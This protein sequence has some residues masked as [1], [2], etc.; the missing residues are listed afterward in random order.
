M[1]VDGLTLSRDYVD[2]ELGQ[3]TLYGLTACGRTVGALFLGEGTL[4]VRSPGPQRTPQ[5]HDRFPDLPG[6]AVLDAAY[7]VGSDG[8]VEDLLAQAGGLQEGRVPPDVWGLVQGRGNGFRYVNPDGWRPPGEILAA[9][10]PAQG[11]LMIEART[12]GV[13]AARVERSLEVLSPWITWVWA[14]T[15]PLGDPREPGLWLRRPTGSTRY[16]TY[17]GFP[18]EQAVADQGTPFALEEPALPWDL[19]A[20]TLSVAVSGPIGPDRQLETLHGTARLQLRARGD[21]SRHVVLAM[22]EGVVSS[23]DHPWDGWEVRGVADADGAPL[24][25]LRSGNRI[26]VELPAAVTEAELVVAWGGDVL[27]PRGMTGVRMFGREAWYPRTAGLDRH[28]VTMSV[29]VPAFWEVIAS[30]HRIGEQVDRRVKTVTS[31]ESV[32]IFGGTL[33]IADV[34]TETV[35]P[36]DGGPLI[37]IHRNPEH[38]LPNARFGPE[39]SERIAALVGLLGPFPYSE[40]EIVERGAGTSGR[41][42]LPGVIT[43]AQFDAPPN[44]V[45]TSRVSADTLLGTLARQ[46]LEVDTGPQGYHDRWLTEG[47]VMWARCMVLEEAELGGRCHGE[48][49]SWRQSW[50]ANVTGGGLGGGARDLIGGAV[51][52]DLGGGSPFANRALRGPLLLHALRLLVG[53]EVVRDAMKE[54]AQA[55]GAYG[56]AEFLEAL[57]DRAGLDLRPWVYGW[58]LNT[59]SLPEA[60]LA[61]SA[62]EAGETWTLVGTGVVDGGRETDPPLPLPTPLLLSVEVGEETLLRRVVL[63]E[64]ESTLRIEGL[65]AKPRNVK[66]DPGRTFPGRVKVTRE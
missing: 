14:P 21:G 5:L 13:K 37:R 19:E 50:L 44:Q 33:V 24:P 63:T 45:V 65:P 62:E 4:G 35:K 30:G 8:A 57:Q 38:P 46:W 22:D 27:E 56:L 54:L 43:M 48:L 41:Q 3:G 29:A 23:Y 9:L 36:L 26:H 60:R 59:P 18:S 15:G 51:W 10:D 28:R 49:A 12:T 6:V 7:I 32:P 25:F 20:A 34:R 16:L 39:L 61:W 66:L 53:D 40:L 58:V 1:E 31:R 11:G 64:R 2:L 55:D 47:M 42:N 52:L 17:G